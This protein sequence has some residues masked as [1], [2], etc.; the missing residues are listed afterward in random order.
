M[1]GKGKMVCFTD[2][3]S[4]VTIIPNNHLLKSQVSNEI[5]YY[6]RM[7]DELIRYTRIK[8]FMLSSTA[9]LTI[10]NSEYVIYDNEMLMLQSLLN[11]DYFKDIVEFNDNKYL[12]NINYNNAIPL[13]SQKYQNQPITIAEQQKLDESEKATGTSIN[14]E[15]VK[16]KLK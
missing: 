13:F 9:Y 7:A 10:G 2:E 8:L 6:G 11:A 15:Y 3:E 16:E 5:I 4:G 1:S 12:K 14:M